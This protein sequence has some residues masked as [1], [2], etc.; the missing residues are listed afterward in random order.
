MPKCEATTFDFDLIQSLY[1]SGDFEYLFQQVV[2]I[3]GQKLFD[4]V[5]TTPAQPYLTASV[6]VDVK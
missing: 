6:T 3:E 5:A 2:T 4:V 1:Q